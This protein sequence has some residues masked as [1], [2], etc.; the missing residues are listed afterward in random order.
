MSQHMRQV[1]RLPYQLPLRMNWSPRVAVSTRRRLEQTT[2]EAT[3]EQR[4]RDLGRAAA[5]TVDQTARGELVAAFAD[6]AGL[7]CGS[8]FLSPLMP[9]RFLRA[10]VM[11]VFLWVLSLGRLITRSAERTVSERR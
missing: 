8:Q 9:T 1:V 11:P 5:Q 10:R 6:G 7:W 4:T 2:E 3:G